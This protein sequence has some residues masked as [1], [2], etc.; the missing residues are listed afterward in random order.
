MKNNNR[1]LVGVLLMFLFLA[2]TS[3][4]GG[5]TE[6][7]ST[8]NTPIDTLTYGTRI[9]N[10]ASALVPAMNAGAA[11]NITMARAIDYRSSDDWDVYLRDTN[12]IVLTDL[13]GPNEGSPAPVTRIRVLLNQFKNIVE[14]VFGTDPNFECTGG[15]AL[16]EGDTLDI[17]FYG[18]LAN[19]TAGDRYFSC[20]TNAGD[21][22]DLQVVTLYGRDS[23]QVFRMVYILDRVAENTESVSDRGTLVRNRSVIESSYVE[24]TENGDNVG[25]MDLKY[26]QS[27]FY[28]GVDDEF[29][30]DDDVVF[31]SR[32][33]ITGD[34]I[35]DA[36]GEASQASG[37][38]TVTKYDRGP[39]ESGGGFWEIINK[40]I[41][42]G[43]Y[44]NE[45][46]SMLNINSNA[47][48]D[49]EAVAGIYCLQSA[50]GSL[51][52]YAE[53]ANCESYEEA[54]P[55]FGRTFPFSLVPAIEE[56]FE[57]KLFFEGNDTDLIADDGSNFEIPEYTTTAS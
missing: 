7:G 36:S 14:N 30:T 31:R 53:P 17:P 44:G 41:G 50:T 3:C 38:F 57:N 54:V 37:D 1:R 23:S 15:S 49:L 42:R 25:F 26:N 12:V 45:D 32:S 24:S 21:G 40:F 52:A 20:I 13:F 51:P 5:G 2:V 33:R 6:T 28:S 55:W 27:T 29:G 16:A 43:A 10:V 22:G 34:A 56:M 35:V 11:A 39:N 9:E 8:D 46:Y 18:S 47:N 19:G 4:G 48:T